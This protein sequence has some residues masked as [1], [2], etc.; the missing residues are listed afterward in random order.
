MQTMLLGLHIETQLN[1]CHTDDTGK[2]DLEMA[3]G[4][5]SSFPETKPYLLSFDFT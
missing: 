4:S 3:K 5:V 2:T 1:C